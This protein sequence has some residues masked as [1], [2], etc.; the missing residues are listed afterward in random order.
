MV[1]N[2]KGPEDDWLEAEPEALAVKSRR[3]EDMTREEL[4]EEVTAWRDRAH[5]RYL[6][7][8]TFDDVD[9]DIADEADGAERFKG[10][11]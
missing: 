3:V 4:A 6:A 7:K 1:K 9:E 5:Q 2:E 11:T 10:T 8:K